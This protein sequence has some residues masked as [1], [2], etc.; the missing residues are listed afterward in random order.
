MSSDTK[1]YDKIPNGFS[2]QV[3]V[4]AIY[5]NVDDVAAL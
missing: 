3:E 1:V 2:P 4:A 5:V